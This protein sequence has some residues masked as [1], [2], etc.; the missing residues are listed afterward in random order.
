MP[1]KYGFLIQEG[2]IYDQQIEKYEIKKRASKNNIIYY[3]EP[4][5]FKRLHVFEPLLLTYEFDKVF[6]ILKFN[7]TLQK[8]RKTRQGRVNRKL[9]YMA[10]MSMSHNYPPT[11]LTQKKFYVY[12]YIQQLKRDF[13]L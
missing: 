8:A 9:H 11:Y 3:I 13:N 2:K 12:K 5:G 10:N 7:S 6:E 4:V 1:V